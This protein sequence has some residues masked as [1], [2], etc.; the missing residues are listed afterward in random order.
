MRQTTSLSFQ[1]GLLGVSFRMQSEA[2]SQKKNSKSRTTFNGGA[3]RRGLPELW[4]L[5]GRWRSHSSRSLWAVGR[6]GRHP[7]LSCMKSHINL[8]LYSPQQFDHHLLVAV[9]STPLLYERN[10]KIFC[11]RFGTHVNFL[12]T[13]KKIVNPHKKACGLKIPH[14]NA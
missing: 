10:P 2:W 8:F 7:Y 1:S 6:G 9:N 4:T 3:L 13:A 14:Y 5:G 11:R 12:D